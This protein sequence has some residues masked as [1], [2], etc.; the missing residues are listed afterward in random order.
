MDERL[1]GLHHWRLKRSGI[2]IDVLRAAWLRSYAKVA[3]WLRSYGLPV[4][5]KT[6]VS[7]SRVRRAA[8]R[9]PPDPSH[10]SLRWPAVPPPRRPR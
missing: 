1:E 5:S 8:P 2:D 3:A 10:A 7:S 9:L 6:L 4:G